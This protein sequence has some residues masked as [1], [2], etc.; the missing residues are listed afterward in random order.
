VPILAEHVQEYL[1]GLRPER[2]P[3]MKEMEELA[4]REGVPI[5]HWE[6]GRLLA[7]LCRV[8]DP[9]VLEVGTAI[10]YSTLHMAEQ[11]ERGRVVTLERDPQRIAQARDYLE[12]GGVAEQVEIVEGD[13]RE[14]IP[15]LEGPFDL[16]FVDATKAEYREYIELAEPKLAGRALLVVDNLLMSGEVALAEGAETY[17]SV[18]NLASARGLNGEL[19]S[20]ERWLGAVLPVGDG[21]GIATRR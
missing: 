17:W 15:T 11:L 4:E 7:V 6:T 5:V 9:V 8:L 1:H 13:A 14:T 21:I 16:L 3:V 19:T 18:E 12:R 20:G 2:S 10:G